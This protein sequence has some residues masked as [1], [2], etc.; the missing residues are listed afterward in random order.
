M[1]SFVAVLVL[2]NMTFL[3]L[4][5][6]QEISCPPAREAEQQTSRLKSER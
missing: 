6:A 3:S 5:L 1:K 4:A 2:Y